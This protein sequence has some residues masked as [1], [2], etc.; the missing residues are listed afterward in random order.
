MRYLPAFMTACLWACSLLAAAAHAAEPGPR[1]DLA[2]METPVGTT[3]DDILTGRAQPGFTPLLTPG[4]AFA[5][6]DGR[7]IWVRIRTDLP[8]A[9][10]PNWQLAIVRAPL[11]R[12]QLKLLP[13]A[14]VVAEASFF[15]AAN[16]ENPWPANFHLPLPSELVGP[17]EFYLHL[18]GDVDGGLHLRLQD[19]ATALLEE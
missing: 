5:A 9:D 1:L 6:R 17:S 15:H 11:D 14:R 19:P 16:E 12:L 10:G 3:L 13:D 4:F 8:V 18:Q 2:V 7:D